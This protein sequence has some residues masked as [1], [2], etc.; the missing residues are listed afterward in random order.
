MIKTIIFDW[1]GVLTIGR[2]TK[3]ILKNISER[4]NIDANGVYSE[5]DK[6]MVEMNSGKIN[7]KEFV[8]KTERKLNLGINEEEM[9]EIFR[10]SIIFSEDVAQIAKELSQK[11]EM[12]MMSDNDEATVENLKKDYPDILTLFSKK[13]FSHELKMRKPDSEFFKHILKDLNAKGV[14]CIFIDDKQKNVDA[15]VNEGMIGIL[16][17]GADKL[18][19]DLL[20]LGI[21]LN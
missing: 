1:G 3:A 11:Y 18:K 21:E 19:E 5:F 13:Y 14:E 9:K 10:K 20:S 17:T 8:Q 15:A 7:F 6:L 4:K 16:F 2:Y 12:I